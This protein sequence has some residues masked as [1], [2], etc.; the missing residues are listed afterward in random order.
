MNLKPENQ[1]SL[2]G[3]HT[4]FSNFIDLY[5]NNK[6]PNKILLSGEKGIGKSTLAYHIIN[7]ILSSDEDL[8][9]DSENFRIN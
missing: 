7:Q 9:Y 5:K 2:Y 1:L 3:H 4:T 6:L 8:S